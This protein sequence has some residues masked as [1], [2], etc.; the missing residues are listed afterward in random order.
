MRVPGY[1]ITG[2][3]ARGGMGIVYRARQLAPDRVVALKMLLPHQLGSH[4]M[5]ERFRLEV[6]TLTGLEHPGILPVYQVGQHAEL[7]FFTMKLATG[8]TLAERKEQFASQWKA[9]AELVATLADAI[10]FAHEHGVLH[11]DLKPGN[12]LFDDA[13]RPYVSDFGLAKLIESDTDLTR[14]ADFLGTPHYVAPEIAARTAQHA[15][16]ST[17]WARFFTNCSR[18]G[19]PSRQRG[20]LRY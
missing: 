12:V 14:S 19:P 7:P 13:G 3:I 11:R 18:A 6:R 4:E 17:A 5:A 1:E 8:G 10:Q 20:S 16:T 2:E 15:A 9:I